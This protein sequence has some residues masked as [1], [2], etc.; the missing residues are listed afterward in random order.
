MPVPLHTRAGHLGNHVTLAKL[1]NAI[2]DVVLSRE[3][4]RNKAFAE[5]NHFIRAYITG[6]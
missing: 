4:V 2:H 1:H 6:D 3:P 5:I